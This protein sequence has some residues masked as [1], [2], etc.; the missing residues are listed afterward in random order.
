VHLARLR[1][2]GSAI[3]GDPAVLASSFSALLEGFCQ[4]WIAGGGEPIGRTLGDDEAIDTMTGLL[5]H[6]I[7]GPT[8]TRSTT[9]AACTEPPQHM[10]SIGRGSDNLA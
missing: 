10:P 6:G 1:D 3:P 7:T 4:I 9:P 8:L 2:T 5:F